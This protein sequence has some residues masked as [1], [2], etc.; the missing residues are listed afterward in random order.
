VV[1]RMMST[2]AWVNFKTFGLTA[3]L[4]LFF[5]T[6]GKLLEKYGIAEDE[7]QG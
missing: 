3:A 6:Q 2:E 4:F 7:T 1:W 5:M